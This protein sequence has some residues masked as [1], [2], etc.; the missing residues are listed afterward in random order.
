MYSKRSGFARMCRFYSYIHRKDVF[1]GHFFK[2]F[3]RIILM[4]ISDIKLSWW[5]AKA[6]V[7]AALTVSIAIAPLS[8]CLSHHV[9]G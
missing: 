2:E 4:F 9:R 7:S 3:L 8:S 1:K 6:A 5:D